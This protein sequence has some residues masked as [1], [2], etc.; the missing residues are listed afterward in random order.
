MHLIFATRGVKHMSDI[1]EAQMQS[2]FFP[3]KRKNLKTGKEEVVPLQGAL[4]PIQ[5]YEYV[6]PKE[7]L[8]DVLTAL[9]IGEGKV[10]PWI[11]SLN[12]KALRK[13]LGLKPIPK[14][15]KVVNRIIA[16]PGVALYPI[17]IKDDAYGA[18]PD[19]GYEQEMV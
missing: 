5:L 17:G 1:F 8:D 12:Q 10:T 11:A 2:Q 7:S 16:R 18:N 4:R 13:A 6:F 19:Y 9:E 15:K 14:Y 3:W